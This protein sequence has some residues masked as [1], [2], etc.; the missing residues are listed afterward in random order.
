MTH[1]TPTQGVKKDEAPC[2]LRDQVPAQPLSSQRMGAFTFPN[3]N[4]VI[5]RIQRCGDDTLDFSKKGHPIEVKATETCTVSLCGWW[6]SGTQS[7]KIF[8]NGQEVAHFQMYPGGESY[9]GNPFP[10]YLRH[11]HRSTDG[12]RVLLSKDERGGMFA[13]VH[14]SVEP[15]SKD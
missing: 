11:E 14:L 9:L 5:Y 12:F 1:A 13:R 15:I 3:V 10:G 7:F 2:K 8:E 4:E 6:S